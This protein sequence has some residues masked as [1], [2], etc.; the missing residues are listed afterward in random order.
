MRS[1]YS[2]SHGELLGKA[3]GS[4]ERA[5]RMIELPGA[6]LAALREPPISPS[7]NHNLQAKGNTPPKKKPRDVRRK[8]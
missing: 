8:S 5:V 2:L 7:H 6:E 4:M 1:L 3:Q